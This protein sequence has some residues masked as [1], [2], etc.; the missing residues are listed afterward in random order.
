VRIL[1]GVLEW[2]YNS[3]PMRKPIEERAESMIAGTQLVR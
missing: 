3:R 1:A 2:A